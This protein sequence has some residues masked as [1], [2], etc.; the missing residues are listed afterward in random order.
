M[1]DA[2]IYTNISYFIL[3]MLIFNIPKI[4]YASGAGLCVTLSRM[5]M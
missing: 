2:Q 3:Y 1:Q 5:L 4:V